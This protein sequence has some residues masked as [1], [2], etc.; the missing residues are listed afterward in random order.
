MRRCPKNIC[1][2]ASSS[3][4]TAALIA[5]SFDCIM[6]LLISPIMISA[7]LASADGAMPYHGGGVGGGGGGGGGGGAGL[8]SHPA[9]M[10]SN[11]RMQREAMEQFFEE[12]TDKGDFYIYS[13]RNE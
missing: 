7:F 12:G 10:A 6:P 4:A 3:V 1:S 5:L 8:G 9:R 2:T 11:A 13:K